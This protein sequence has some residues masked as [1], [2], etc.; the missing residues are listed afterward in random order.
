MAGSPP[1]IVV[2]ADLIAIAELLPEGAYLNVP[3]KIDVV[4][5]GETLGHISKTLAGKFLYTEYVR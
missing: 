2:L 5:P 1:V 4:R 3:D